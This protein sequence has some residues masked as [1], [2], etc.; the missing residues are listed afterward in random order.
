M[1]IILGIEIDHEVEK[2]RKEMAD[3]EV[4]EKNFEH[5]VISFFRVGRQIQILIPFELSNV[6]VELFEQS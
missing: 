4:G 2:N 6:V 3:D 1:P 5:F